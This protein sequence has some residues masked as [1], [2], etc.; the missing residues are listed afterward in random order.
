MS[1]F[2]VGLLVAAVVVAVTL[3]APAQD[4]RCQ[5][6]EVTLNFVEAELRDVV[7][8]IS[9]A[10]GRRFILSGALPES[11]ITIISPLPVCPSEAYQAFLSALAMQGIAVV[12]NGRF[13]LVMTA[14][15]A[16]RGHIPIITDD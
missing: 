2:R 1:V 4:S 11:R 9:S 7:A 10:T 6:R 14:N 8:V 3:E 15:Q 16:T 12:R 13:H 5:G